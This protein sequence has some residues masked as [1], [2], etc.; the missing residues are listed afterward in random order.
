MYSNCFLGEVHEIQL[1]VIIRGK[2][3]QNFCIVSHDDM[4]FVYNS[5]TQNSED[6]RKYF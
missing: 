4:K 1:E 3:K 5:K 2:K 6:I